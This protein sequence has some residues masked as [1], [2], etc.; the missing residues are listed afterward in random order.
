MIIILSKAE[1]HVLAKVRMRRFLVLLQQAPSFN[2][3]MVTFKQKVI[4]KK[5]FEVMYIRKD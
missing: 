2:L 3:L 1:K 4:K 5:R